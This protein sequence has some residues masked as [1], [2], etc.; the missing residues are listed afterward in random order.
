MVDVRHVAQHFCGDMIRRLMFGKRYFSGNLPAASS[1]TGPGRDELA[2]V[3]AL[4][5]LLNHVY[6]FCVSDYFPALQGLDLEGHELVSKNVMK[7]L[8]RFHDP[9][10]DDRIRESSKINRADDKKVARDFLD[11]LVFLQDAQGQPLLSR[12]DIRAQTA[13]RTLVT[14]PPPQPT[15]IYVQKKSFFLTTNDRLAGNYV[16]NN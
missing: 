10:I 6:S 12:E 15:Y 7:A 5:T 3:A 1:T 14:W 4:F 16:C 8:N 9:I 11:V 2:H 13:V